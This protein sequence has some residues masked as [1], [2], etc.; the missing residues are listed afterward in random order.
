MDLKLFFSWQSDSDT[1][2]LHHTRFIREC[3]QTAIKNV[4]KE[5]RYITIKY[6]EGIGG[7]SGSPELISEIEKRIKEA[8]IFCRRSHLYKQRDIFD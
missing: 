5:L 1:K 4:N 8:H 3:I 6:Q 2:K 7:V